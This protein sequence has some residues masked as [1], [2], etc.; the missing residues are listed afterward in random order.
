MAVD[1]TGFS[2][3]TYYSWRRNESRREY[4]KLHAAVGLLYKAIPSMEVATGQVGD[5]TQ[6]PP[7][8]CRTGESCSLLC[9]AALG[10][11]LSGLS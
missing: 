5:T 4:I 3:K 10:I 1:A 8:L 6:L 11:L 7:M 9:L 2:P